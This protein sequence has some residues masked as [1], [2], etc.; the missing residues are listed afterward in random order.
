MLCFK[1]DNIKIHLWF[2]YRSVEKHTGKVHLG[3]RN[4]VCDICGMAYGD[5]S[6]LKIHIIRHSDTK[7]F[8]CEHCDYATFDKG[9]YK[10]GFGIKEIIVLRM[11][12]LKFLS[13]F[14]CMFN[15]VLVSYNTS[16]LNEVYP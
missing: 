14:K 8:P 13:K 4:Y 3:I 16:V 12:F 5:E 9:N 6:E 7:T 10:S 15:V 1:R 2:S 11:L